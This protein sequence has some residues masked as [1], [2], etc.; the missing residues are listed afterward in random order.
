M[1]HDLSKVNSSDS[2]KAN[3][4]EK[5]VEAIKESARVSLLAN[6]INFQYIN[7]N[8]D[9]LANPNESA[10]G[11]TDMSLQVI[12]KRRNA[13]RQKNVHDK[14]GHKFVVKYFAHPTRCFY[15]ED[16]FW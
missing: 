10:G 12:N 4:Q 1:E 13:I 16:F 8:L 6:E 14:N 15:C 11:T 3:E 2:Q 9:S 7:G 5:M